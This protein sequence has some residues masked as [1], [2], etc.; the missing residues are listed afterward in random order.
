MNNNNRDGLTGSVLNA[1]RP[2]NII[3]KILYMAV[4]ISLLSIRE[5]IA[6]LNLAGQTG[7]KWYTAILPA[8]RDGLATVFVSIWELI[9]DIGSL[10]FIMISDGAIGNMIFGTL[11]LMGAMYVV[12]QP[13]S[14]LINALD[15]SKNDV[16]SGLFKIGAT[17]VAVVIISAIVYYTSD[18][19]SVLTG[20]TEII[21][22]QIINNTVTNITQLNQTNIINMI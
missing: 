9:V 13:V 6:Y 15:G 2:S 17:L 20:A 8:Y 4:I 5:F 18:A 19:Q 21:N 3:K 11:F 1:L 10:Q 12:Y 7:S 16:A 22:K 14:L